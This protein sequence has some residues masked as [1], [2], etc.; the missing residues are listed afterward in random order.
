M[1]VAASEPA[2]VAVPA[3]RAIMLDRSCAEDGIPAAMEAGF[4]TLMQIA[5]KH[6]IRFAGAP[7]AIYRAY[8][9]EGVQFTLAVPVAGRVGSD[10]G[11]ARIGTLPEAKTLR[12]MHTG[13][14]DG[15]MKTYG[16]I[17]S[18]MVDHKYMKA[19]SDWDRYMPMWEEYLNDPTTTPPDELITYI[20]LPLTG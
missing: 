11:E 5:Q 4:G 13:P 12:F 16:A 2:K 14:Y 6:R 8:G 7:R 10:L 15:L 18:W 19:E 17:T 1:T 3:T 20:H 9:P